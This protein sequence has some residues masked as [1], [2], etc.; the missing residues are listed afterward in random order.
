MHDIDE[1][2]T[3]EIARVLDIPLNTVYSRLRVA[4]KELAKAL[5]KLGVTGGAQ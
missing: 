2:P 3:H 1:V 4:R 5:T